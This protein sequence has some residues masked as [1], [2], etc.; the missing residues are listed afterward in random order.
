MA[1]KIIPRTPVDSQ[2]PTPL[3][4]AKAR[5]AVLTAPEETWLITL[6]QHFPGADPALW[7]LNRE[8]YSPEAEAKAAKKRATRRKRNARRRANRST[9][10]KKANASDVLHRATA[11]QLE[12]VN[13]NDDDSDDE[14]SEE[15]SRLIPYTVNGITRLLEVK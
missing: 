2:K 15:E 9:G 6:E 14:E 1:K 13:N 10:S 7:Q 8:S 3:S 12:R 4:V 11:E 5:I